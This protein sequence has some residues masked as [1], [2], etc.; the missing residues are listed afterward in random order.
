[1]YRGGGSIGIVGAA[2]SGLLLAN[3][4]NDPQVRVLATVKSNLG[5][6][7]ESL[8]FTIAASEGLPHIEWI[9]TTEHTAEQ[10]LAPQTAEE[11]GATQEAAEFLRQTLSEGPLEAKGILKMA[12]SL[13]ISKSSLYRAKRLIGESY[14]AGLGSWYWGLKKGPEHNENLHVH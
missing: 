3:D 13:G 5:K 7:A 1:M 12:E 4:P 10:L 8:S 9:G 6:H 14:K 2:R 11:H